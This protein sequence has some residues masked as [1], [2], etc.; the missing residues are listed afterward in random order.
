VKLPH[1]LPQPRRGPFDPAPAGKLS[2]ALPALTVMSGS[3][4]TIWP[5]I[6]NIP[7]LPP[8]GLLMLLGWRLMRSDNFYIWAAL[9]L[10]LFD[11][12]LSG[13]PLGSSM[14]LWTLCFFAIDLIEQRLM[15]RD[16]WQDWLIASGAI[17]F[18][19]I[20][21]RYFATPI[22][23]HVD[24]LLLMQAIISIMSFPIVARLCA[25]LDGKRES[26]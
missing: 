20:V 25:W 10:G 14:L 22:A 11:D 19:L 12:M 7:V 9:P 5:V 1:P 6:A 2:R 23:A 15:F 21:G 18:C 4:V 13:Q 16:F 8:I 26:A 3:L 17:S 24:T